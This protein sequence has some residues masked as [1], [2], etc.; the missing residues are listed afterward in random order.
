M[1]N[2]CLVM[3]SDNQ[4]GKNLL[5]NPSWGATKASLQADSRW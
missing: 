2:P 4:N 1:N 5:G 3:I